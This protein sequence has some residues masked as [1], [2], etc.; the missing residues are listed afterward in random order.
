MKICLLG[1]GAIGCFIAGHLAQVPGCEVSVVGRGEQLNAIK[2]S[3]LRVLTPHGDLQARIQATDRPE[4]LGIQDYVFITLKSN[5]VP[6]ALDQLSPLIGNHTVVLP[7]TTGIPFWFFD[8]DANGGLRL[9]RVDPGDR[10]RTAI[11]PWRVLGCVYWMPVE[12]IA[13]GI[14]RQHG[15]RGSFPVGEP[16]GTPSQRVSQL[17]AAMRAGG[18]D[19]SVSLDIR[20]EIWMKA[21]SSLCLNPIASL[22][23]ATLGQIGASA[24]LARLVRQ[25]MLEADAM[26][27]QLGVRPCTSVDERIQLA[28]QAGPHRMSMFLMPS[29]HR[30]TTFANWRGF[31]RRP[32]ISSWRSWHCGRPAPD[33]HRRAG[34]LREQGCAYVTLHVEPTRPTYVPQS[35]SHM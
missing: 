3:G 35:P 24:E 2:R 25:M 8:G 34:R 31:R 23:R 12:V 13:P 15:L 20:A 29:R 19:T 18:L 28:F 11:E 16:D 14:V 17:A 9:P 1:A 4:G 33:R 6:A 27:L 7:P 22:T 32:W 21:V 10:Q 26:A 30:S 5:E